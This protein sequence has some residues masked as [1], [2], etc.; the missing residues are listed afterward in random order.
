MYNLYD[1]EFQDIENDME[2]RKKLLE[3][4]EQI[5]SNENTRETSTKIS[6]IQRQWKRI[7]FSESAYEQEL[8]EKYDQYMDAFHSKRKEA[9]HS[10]KEYKQNLI[11]QAKTIV[12]T[13]DVKN[14]NEVMNDFMAQWKMAG[15]AGKEEDDRL[16]EE[17]NT[18]RQSYF[19]QKHQ[20]WEDAQVKY[21]HA[22]Q[23]KQELIDQAASLCESDDW[24]KTSEV[25]RNLMERWKS[26]GSAGKQYEDA[27]WNEFH[28][29]RQKFYDRRNEHYEEIRS[30][31][32][33]K[34]ELKRTLIEQAN[35]IVNALDYSKEHNDKMKQLH[36]EW[37]K[38]G[39]CG[40]ER[41][42]AI[43]SE[44]RTIM[45]QYFQG[46]K[47]YHDQKHA[48]WRQNMMDA[49]TRKQELIQE[50]KRQ[51]KWMHNEIVGLIGQ[52]AIDDMQDEIEE[53]EDFITELE[54][55]ISDIDRKL[56]E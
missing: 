46:L 16:W 38:I 47:D 54:E 45:D 8:I 44:F 49:R 4:L 53:K 25:Y 2:T 9:F 15:S 5:D 11:Q 56:A 10:N 40:K 52:K 1:D 23:V 26:A 37:K 29:Q 48:N 31:Q 30:E 6:N 18:V 50:Q 51:M 28:G 13:N 21:E 19:D 17:F 43:W 36:V 14:S 27:L 55:Q 39:S 24:Q 35:A 3:E 20:Q 34:Y 33:Q 32:D 7:P 22:R 41:E 42:D 12:Q